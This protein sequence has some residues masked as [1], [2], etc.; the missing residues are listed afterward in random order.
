MTLSRKSPLRRFYRWTILAGFGLLGL[1]ATALVT[2][3]M[4]SN[5]Q[6]RL[7]QRFKIAASERAKL[8]IRA[9]EEPLGQLIVLQRLFHS[10]AQVD[11]P[12]FKKFVDPMTAK[13]G[14]QGYGW[15]PMVTAAE[16]SGFENTGRQLWGKD[17][18]I[19]ER[20][21]DGNA[22][23]V[24]LRQ[25]YYPVLF[26]LPIESNRKALGLNLHAA[27]N[28]GPVID[29]SIDSGD[30]AAS[31]VSRLIIDSQISDTVVI[32]MPVYRDGIVPAAQLE[33]R[34][35]VRG[36]LIGVLN[37]G[38]LFDLANS[39][40]PQSGLHASLF[41]PSMPEGKQ[42]V[43]RWASGENIEASPHLPTALS[44]SQNFELADR[45]M[46]VR[47]EAA[48]DWLE[49]N[50]TNSAAFIPV[51]GVL[52]TLLLLVYL[53][54]LLG[55]SELADSLEVA[56]AEDQVQ[57][58][59]AEAWADKLSMAVEQNPVT[60]YIVDLDGRIEYVNNKFVETT[61]YS[62]EEAIGQNTSMLRPED[63]DP[64]VYQAVWATI[65]SGQI[66]RGELQS[67]RRDGT[68]Y[69]DR[70]LISPIRSRDG[71][72][73]N[74]V[75]IK[76]DITELKASQQHIEFLAHHDPL[77]GLPNRLLLRDR[78][79][80]ARAQAARKQSR[81]ALMFL[82]L[83]RFKTIN[84]SLGHPVGDN[85]LNQVVERLKGCVRESD[86]ISRQGGD[87]FIILLN[88]VRD[89]EAVSRVADKIHQRMGEPIM[90]A[91][92]LL[93]TSFSIGIALYPDDG[94]DFDS[95]LQKADTAMYH[96]KEAGRNGHRFFTEQMN[97]QVVEHMT[98][99]TQLRQALGNKEFVLHY[100]PQM[101]LKEG[102]IIGVE[103][104]IRWDSPEN[105]MVSP[106][107]FI[108]VAEDSGLIVPIG[109]WVLGE[110][111]R[112]ARAWQ[113]AG[114]A[115]FVVA[116]NLSAVQ[117][118]RQDLVTAVIN[119]LVLA[120]LDAQWLELELTESILIQDAETTL[121]SVHRL[122]ALGV[123][124]SVDDFGTG[125]SSLAYL[126]RFAVDKL[127]IDQS[128]VRGLATDPDDA[129]IVRAI[130]QMAHSL[131]LK[132]IAEGVETE[133]LAQML[134]LFHCDEIQGYWFAR[135]MPADQLENF[136][137]NH[138]SP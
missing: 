25:R 81:L 15:A 96:A 118:K 108:P 3:A 104:L 114:L 56:H 94:D 91:N 4:V 14:V 30:L 95:L 82:D 55:R 130:I 22:L 74:Y 122:K 88:D 75:A 9:F 7:E 52:L 111:C 136:V 29:R 119:A 135:P 110:A 10:V 65:E 97:R 69:W 8:I 1:V 16:R 51:L 58:R 37:I 64:A 23:P 17:F 90:A 76:E 47:I 98:M 31:E 107:K 109:A 12:V 83:D 18:V 126:K 84:D 44:Y 134:Q 36:V 128:F 78:V 28:R 121:D 59:A 48:P 80:Q 99:E 113:D 63:A 35:K 33:R 54:S 46:V 103:A 53:R 32:T 102:A 112:Q 106:A 26:A 20:D 34:S 71:E 62:R 85:L 124:L 127:K 6:E 86:T 66:W 68:L 73:T 125:Y 13:A 39:T 131:K 138:K 77:T 57:R 72:I 87:E 38:I 93:M 41:D 27:E 21:A 5:S 45:V 89:G 116:V 137:R 40:A 50:A 2:T 70:V 92:Q 120:D 129:A 100:Q 115:P 43:H 42:L 132:T 101:D 19:S 60:I 24:K 133:E 49:T 79:E 117:F 123:K 67:R 11:W 61:G 105:G